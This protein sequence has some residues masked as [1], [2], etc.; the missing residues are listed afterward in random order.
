MLKFYHLTILIVNPN[1]PGHV[2]TLPPRLHHL[3]TVTI[4][5]QLQ[6]VHIDF[7][8]RNSRGPVCLVPPPHDSARSIR[9]NATLGT[10]HVHTM[11]RVAF[12]G[13]NPVFIF[14]APTFSRRPPLYLRAFW[15]IVKIMAPTGAGHIATGHCRKV[16][17]R[18]KD[19]ERQRVADVAAD[20][21]IVGGCRMA[22]GA[23]RGGD[24]GKWG[25]FGDGGE[26][27]WWFRCWVPRRL[28]FRL[29]TR[30][31]LVIASD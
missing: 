6:L 29:W 17:F 14:A 10:F 16:R 1:I 19:K 22:V 20:S 30:S 15:A 23:G 27:W 5:L 24:I 12:V 26:S 9:E 18:R 28:R 2:S 31:K 13:S 21:G 3:P 7:L 8:K 25:V 4:N 11:G